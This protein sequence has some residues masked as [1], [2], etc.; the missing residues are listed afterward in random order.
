M[1]LHIRK[2][3]FFIIFMICVDTCFG[4]DFDYFGYRFRLHFGT[5]FVFFLCFS[6][7]VFL[8]VLGML[9]FRFYKISDQKMNPKTSAAGLAASGLVRPP[10]PIFLHTCQSYCGNTYKC[11]SKGFLEFKILIKV[12][13]HICEHCPRKT[14]KCAVTRNQKKIP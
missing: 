5:L 6:A 12:F 2:T 11:D 7:I 14:Y 8:I 9:I 13:L 3:L 1:F 10:S 4:I